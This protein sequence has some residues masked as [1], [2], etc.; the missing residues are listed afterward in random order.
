MVEKNDG[1]SESKW[2]CLS[3]NE[4]YSSYLYHE[5]VK[6]GICKIFEKESDEDVLFVG[7][8]LEEGI[9]ENALET[10]VFVKCE[11]ICKYRF[12]LEKSR[13]IKTILNS[14]NS[15]VFISELEI[16][17]LKKDWAK[18]KQEEDIVFFYG[19]IVNVK[20]GV[21]EKLNGIIIDKKNKKEMV[22]LFKFSVGYRIVNLHNDNLVKKNNV[23]EI[24][25]V[26]YIKNG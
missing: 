23:F 16:E 1:G 13:Y 24:I 5:Q 21:Y 25:K 4:R 10:Y 20:R 7:N 19:D 12:Q 3:I 22:V 17:A 18:K 6:N 8:T 11:D 2:V 14:F 15:I 9:I 26:P